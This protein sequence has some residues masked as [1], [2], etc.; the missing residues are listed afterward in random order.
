MAKTFAHA[1]FSPS[2]KAWLK[3][4]RN[5]ILSRIEQ[6][7]AVQ[8]GTE[9][10]E[11]A[12]KAIDLGVKLDPSNGCLSQYVSD[13]IELGMNTEI[14]VSYSPDIQGTADAI[15]F[16][17]ESGWLY[18]FDLKTGERKADITQCIIYAAIWCLQFR[19]E[20][21]T[22]KFDLRIYSG[23]YPVRLASD[24]ELPDQEPVNLTI[25]NACQQIR[26]IQSIIE[27]G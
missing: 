17:P 5:K 13:C 27:G 12:K 22:I 19:V 6:F 24:D 8:R 25:E 20:P 11:L 9:L 1:M 14:L 4:D 26:Y 21:L 16:N 23:R 10:H 7:R 2:D 3:Y 15:L 18:V